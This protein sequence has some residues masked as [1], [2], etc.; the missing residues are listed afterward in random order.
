MAEISFREYPFSFW[1]MAAG[2]SRL[3]ACLSVLERVHVPHFLAA[4]V[5]PVIMKSTD[6]LQLTVWL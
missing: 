2:A 3:Q 1:A 6:P 4:R 5:T